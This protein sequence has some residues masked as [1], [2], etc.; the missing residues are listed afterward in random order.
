M[1]HWQVKQYSHPTMEA[2]RSLY[3]DCV[4]LADYLVRAGLLVDVSEA[5]TR[6]LPDCF[7]CR[8]KEGR[9]RPWVGLPPLLLDFAREAGHTHREVVSTSITYLL[10]NSPESLLCLGYDPQFGGLDT[11][12]R[13]LHL[14]TTGNRLYTAR[15]QAFRCAFGDAALLTLLCDPALCI[16]EPLPPLARGCLLQIAGAPIGREKWASGPAVGSVVAAAPLTAVQPAQQNHRLH[17]QGSWSLPTD[18]LLYSF[19]WG[20][21]GNGLLPSHILPALSAAS[22]DIR[23]GGS[24]SSG[25]GAV[26]GGGG[27]GGRPSTASKPPAGEGHAK[28]LMHH[29]FV[30][31]PHIRHLELLARHKSSTSAAGASYFAPVDPAFSPARLMA[32]LKAAMGKLS[33]ARAGSLP[34]T[35]V[36]GRA[37]LGGRAAAARSKSVGASSSLG[38]SASSSSSGGSSAALQRGR[39]R[40]FRRNALPLPTYPDL[41]THLP[42][43]LLSAV[44]LF[45]E[46]LSRYGAIP[47]EEILNKHCPERD[48]AAMGPGE[49]KRARLGEGVASAA[50]P[51]P[52]VAA[53]SPPAMLEI[54]TPLSTG[55]MGF[56]R[57]ALARL[58]PK[59]LWGGSCHNRRL[60]LSS[61]FSVLSTGRNQSAHVCDLLSGFR[62]RDFSALG[63]GG[64]DTRMQALYSHAWVLWVVMGLVLPLV[65]ANF[66]VTD[67]EVAQAQLL[68]FRK[69]V[70]WRASS[71]ALAALLPLLGL[72]PVVPASAQQPSSLTALAPLGYASMR[73]VPKALGLRPIMN[74]SARHRAWPPTLSATLARRGAERAASGRAPSGSGGKGEGGKGPLKRTAPSLPPAPRHLSAAAT[75]AAAAAPFSKPP[76]WQSVNAQLRLLHEVLKFERKRSPSLSGGAVFGMDGVHTALRRF[77]SLRRGEAAAA[78]AAASARG[79]SGKRSRA[80]PPSTFAL[81]T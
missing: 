13:C 57:E 72:C 56:V 79:P 67:G 46:L 76:P 35:Q 27:G 60:L 7:V 29:I 16:F 23:G 59:A 49:H 77:N 58:L 14:N 69:R 28:A 41:P 36:Q 2:L 65:R 15:W 34:P 18:A 63:S 78:G 17:T 52:P 74:L 33:R 48:G 10:K 70:W 64:C 51:A 68:F 43:G 73:L 19:S 1:W 5:R 11:T 71:R 47:W 81:Q 21:R 61:V 32:S 54:A 50:P 25:S 62:T 53:Y 26:S 40:L 80:P 37:P 22:K 31:A 42:P 45:G 24:S 20:A 9:F 66:Y 8:R 3:R 4:P 30:A 12:L 75:A 44:P 55:V 6:D 38:I 39:G